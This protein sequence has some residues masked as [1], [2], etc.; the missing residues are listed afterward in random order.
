MRQHRRC[1]DCRLRFAVPLG[2]LNFATYGYIL[3]NGR[4]VLDGTAVELRDNEDVKE[5]YL[6]VAEGRRKSI[7]P[8]EGRVINASTLKAP[9]PNA[10]TKSMPPIIERCI[11]YP[12]ILVWGAIALELQMR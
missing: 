8:A 3:E 10:T 4:V 12:D 2:A 7:S 9:A 6:G 1:R 11:P 5:F